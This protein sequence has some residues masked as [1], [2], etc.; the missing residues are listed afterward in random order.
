MRDQVLGLGSRISV[1][2]I[3][4]W[5]RDSGLGFRQLQVQGLWGHS[6]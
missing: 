1:L 3:R 5:F 2:G 6:V 4:V